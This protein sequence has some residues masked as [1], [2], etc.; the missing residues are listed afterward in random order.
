MERH[1]WRVVAGFLLIVVGVVLTLAELNI[2]DMQ[3]GLI[4]LT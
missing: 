3:P 1:W 4:L 2:I